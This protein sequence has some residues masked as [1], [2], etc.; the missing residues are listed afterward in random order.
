MDSSPSLLLLLDTLRR[1]TRP[2]NT[3][4]LTPPLLPPTSAVLLRALIAFSNVACVQ[5][6]RL[7]RDHCHVLSP[8]IFPLHTEPRVV[9]AWATLICSVTAY[10]RETAQVFVELGVVEV[11]QRLL[12]YMGE[13]SRCA[14]R[15]LRCLVNLGMGF[16]S[17]HPPVLP[18]S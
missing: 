3:T 15:G 9:E 5:T 17:G 11:L 18:V 2:E 7:T 1:M 10:H 12:L 6:L 16:A 14:V 8:L 13:N 4:A